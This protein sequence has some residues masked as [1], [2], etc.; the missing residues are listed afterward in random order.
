MFCIADVADESQQIKWKIGEVA[1][2]SAVVVILIAIVIGGVTFFVRR[3]KVFRT[4]HS[5][6]TDIE[7]H[8]HSEKLLSSMPETT[9]STS[10]S[11]E[12]SNSYVKSK[13]VVKC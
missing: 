11:G 7:A 12:N 6:L 8:K 4:R 13:Q 3:G 9:T 1:F 2:I 10:G 5:Y